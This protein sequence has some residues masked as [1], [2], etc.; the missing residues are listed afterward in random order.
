MKL[1]QLTM[2]IVGNRLQQIARKK[3]ETRDEEQLARLEKAEIAGQTAIEKF[4]AVISF[5]V[6]KDAF[7]NYEAQKLILLTGNG[8]KP[9]QNESTQEVIDESFR[10][11]TIAFDAYSV[12][13]ELSSNWREVPK[14]T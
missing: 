2:S 9:S 11:S 7:L 4:D 13:M 10:L 5:L 3:T 1:V 8:K 12:F 6:N 14:T